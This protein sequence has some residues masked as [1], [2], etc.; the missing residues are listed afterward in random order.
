METRQKKREVAEQYEERDKP[1]SSGAWRV[2]G[3]ELS[4]LNA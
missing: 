1:E 3:A 2:C 4:T